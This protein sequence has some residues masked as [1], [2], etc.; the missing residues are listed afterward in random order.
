MATVGGTSAILE[1]GSG[2]SKRLSLAGFASWVAWRS[3]YL[4]RL[5]SL[6]NRWGRR[7]AARAGVLETRSCVAQQD[8]WLLGGAAQQALPSL[9]MRGRARA[10]RPPRAWHPRLAG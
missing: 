7:Q 9:L 8:T 10:A 2:T 3:A 1:L 6:R 5:G 4:T